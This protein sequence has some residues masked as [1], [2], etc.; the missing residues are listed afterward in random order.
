MKAPAMTSSSRRPKSPSSK[1]ASSETMTLSPAILP[2]P[3]SVPGCGPS[4]A[5]RRGR[6]AE[7][8]RGPG[9]WA[10]VGAL[11]APGDISTL[12]DFEGDGDSARFGLGLAGDRLAP[13]R[14]LSPAVRR[15]YLGTG[16]WRARGPAGGGPLRGGVLGRALDLV[17]RE[18]PAG[19]GHMG[20]ARSIRVP[21]AGRARGAST[22]PRANSSASSIW[23]GARCGRFRPIATPPAGCCCP[24]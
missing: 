16:R 18:D 24:M 7:R 15:S 9:W 1:T 13:C 22:M 23:P 12:A 20:R 8:R 17:A 11:P 6:G 2:S 10:P 3:T 5:R 19:A 4:R 14:V 21:M